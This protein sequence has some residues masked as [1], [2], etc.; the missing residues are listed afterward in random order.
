MRRLLAV[1]SAVGVIL[2]LAGPVSAAG[3]PAMAFDPGIA[4]SFGLEVYQGDG[5][6][7]ISHE[8]SH[9]QG[10]SGWLLWGGHGTD[11]T[12]VNTDSGETYS[13]PAT[14]AV[15]RMVMHEDGS[16]TLFMTGGNVLVMFPTDDPAGPSTT[17]YIGRVV[18]DF[19]AAG[20]TTLRSASG[21]SIDIC[22][23]LA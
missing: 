21:R 20:N 2:A 12:F 1:V 4:C 14:G 18:A 15:N 3:A 11:L 17:V 22:A 19:D 9:G 23:A 5:G 6:P 10:G 16:S 7:I 8:F 13:T